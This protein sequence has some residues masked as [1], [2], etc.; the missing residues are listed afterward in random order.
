MTEGEDW[1]YQARKMR[2]ESVMKEVDISKEPNEV[3]LD[4][5]YGVSSVGLHMKAKNEGLFDRELCQQREKLV[6][7]INR[8]KEFLWKEIK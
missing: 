5:F 6:G 7:L 8:I 1:K 2:I 4:V 3:Y